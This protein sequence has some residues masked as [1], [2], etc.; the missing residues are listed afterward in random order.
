VSGSSESFR[1]HGPPHSQ[2]DASQEDTWPSTLQPDKAAGRG[3]EARSQRAE[4]EPRRA[5]GAPDQDEIRTPT[6][7]RP[8]PPGNGLSSPSG[9]ASPFLRFLVG[10][11]L[12]LSLASLALNAYLIYSFMSVRQTAVEMLD[13]ALIGLESVV[14]EGLYYEYRLE[15]SFPIAAEVPIQ[16]EMT[17]PFEGEVPINTT[18]QVPIDAGVLGTFMFDVPINTSVHV[19]TEIPVQIDETFEVST[20]IPVSMTIPIELDGDDP[21][22]QEFLNRVRQWLLDLR[23]FFGPGA[24]RPASSNP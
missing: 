14:E 21:A 3:L 22:V 17:F 18:V 11:A 13:S 15:Q 8:S 16:E 10:L 5:A 24:P 23:R 19:E 20:T 1:K 9:R 12:V 7:F 2:A 6:P 4:A